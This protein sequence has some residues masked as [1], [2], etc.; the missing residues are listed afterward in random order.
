[1]GKVSPG[2]PAACDVGLCASYLSVSKS[3]VRKWIKQGLLHPFHFP[4]AGPKDGPINKV[5]VRLDELQR[6]LDECSGPA[7]AAPSSEINQEAR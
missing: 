2:W 4:R 5:Y 7:P 6:F 3:T 1:M